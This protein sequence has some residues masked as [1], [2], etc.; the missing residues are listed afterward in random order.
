MSIRLGR[1]SIAMSHVR[2]TLML[3]AA[4]I[5]FYRGWRI[6]T[7]QLAWIAYGLGLL[8][9]AL[10]LWHLLRPPPAPRR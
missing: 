10:A 5:A 1:E 4:A 6:H 8:A 3:V 2:G 7:G 9:L